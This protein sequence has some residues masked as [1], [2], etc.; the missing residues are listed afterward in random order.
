[1]K[2]EQK[3]TCPSA[4]PREGAVLLGIVKRNGEVGL[5]GEHME[6]DNHFLQTAREGRELEQRFRFASPCITS[7]CA[8]WS[9]G[10]C[11][12]PD[13]ARKLALVQAAETG[14]LPACSIRSS[15][16]WYMQEG[17]RA[18]RLCPKI[19][20]GYAALETPFQ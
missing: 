19:I 17:A 13:I 2:T 1:M 3:A 4:A 12:V 8:N 11:M 5:L 7:G 16:R 14:E 6:V 10:H 9:G 15:C 18:C 20:T